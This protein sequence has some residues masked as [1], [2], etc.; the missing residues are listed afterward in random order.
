MEVLNKQNIGKF[1]SSIH[2]NNEIYEIFPKI[3]GPTFTEIS[4]SQ[5]TQE[6]IITLNR[7]FKNDRP[8]LLVKFKIMIANSSLSF[9]MYSIFEYLI[10]FIIDQAVE[11]SIGNTPINQQPELSADDIYMSLFI[12]FDKNVLKYI[13]DS[14]NTELPPREIILSKHNSPNPVEQNSPIRLIIKTIYPNKRVSDDGIYFIQN[15]IIYLGYK[16]QSLNQRS[17]FL[18]SLP[19]NEFFIHST[20]LNPTLK[21]YKIE[22]LVTDLVLKNINTIYISSNDI[23]TNILH[24]KYYNFISQF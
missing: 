17:L 21:N 13:R 22:F 9:G 2:I 4:K 11:I 14:K 8:M 20:N 19:N 1:I 16:H 5:T 15:L 24:N 7:I 18:D 23:L 10:K 12:A 6:L 3:F